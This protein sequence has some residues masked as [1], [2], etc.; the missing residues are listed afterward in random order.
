MY[1]GSRFAKVQTLGM[2]ISKIACVLF[3]TLSTLAADELS[4]EEKEADR[5]AIRYVLIE[6]A[7]KGVPRADTANVLELSPNHLYI[8][9]QRFS[10][11]ADHDSGQCSIWARESDDGGKT[12][13]A[14]REIIVAREHD[15]SVMMPALCRTVNGDLLL[16]ANRI[17]SLASTTM[18]LYRSQD[19]GKSWR[20]EGSIWEKSTGFWVQGGAT[21]LLQLS[22]GRLIFAYHFGLEGAQDQKNDVCCMI[23]DNDGKNWRRSPDTIKL[24]LRG[25]MEPSIAEL[26]TGRLVMSLRTQLGSPFISRSTDGGETWDPPQ[27]S[28]LIGPESSTC[29]RRLPDTDTLALF[30]NNCRYRPEKLHCGDRTRLSAAISRDAGR[31]WTRIGDIETDRSQRYYNVNC[32]FLMSGSAMVTYCVSPAKWSRRLPTTLKCAIIPRGFFNTEGEMIKENSVAVE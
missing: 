14:A 6:P 24:P 3:S 4:L 21:Q 27:T 32:T 7:T 31:S 2:L 16:L 1:I 8:A 26:S 13:G 23:S 19:Q 11:L 22:N 12:W 9:Y 15:Q 10:N 20:L 5:E 30:W 17:H 28:G 29:L 25:A 18:E